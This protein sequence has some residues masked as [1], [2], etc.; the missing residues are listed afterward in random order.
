MMRKQLTDLHECGGEPVAVLRPS[1]AAIYGRFGYGPATRG[2]QLPCEKRSMVFRP[3][4]EFGDGTIRFLGRDEAR[5]LIEKVYD[6]VRTG[7]VGRPDRTDR[8]WDSRL[9]DEPQARAGATSL[10]F[11]VHQD[12]GTSGRR[13]PGAGRAPLRDAAGPRPGP[14]RQLLPLEHRALPASGRW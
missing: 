9:F 11:A 5:P 1:E 7:A 8:S 14:E 2:A 3:G 4:T 12:P 6:Q 13:R 10:R